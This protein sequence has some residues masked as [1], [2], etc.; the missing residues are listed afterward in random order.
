MSSALL[1]DEPTVGR[2]RPSTPEPDP[3]V[4]A[5]QVRLEETLL[6]RIREAARSLGL[7]V[8]A[9]LRMVAIERMDKMD[10]ERADRKDD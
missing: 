7:T 4:V 2:A 10:A 8:S 9:F 3:K 5:F 6:A 1:K